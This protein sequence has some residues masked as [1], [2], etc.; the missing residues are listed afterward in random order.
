VETTYIQKQKKKNRGLT[1][2]TFL[3][4]F[5]VQKWS[6][7]RLVINYLQRHEN[8]GMVDQPGRHVDI[9]VG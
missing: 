2:Q 9:V 3:S 1:A 7:G 8:D 5:K 6:E 4:D